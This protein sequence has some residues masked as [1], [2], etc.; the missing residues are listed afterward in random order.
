MEEKSE[1]FCLAAVGQEAWTLRRILE[2][3]KTYEIYLAAVAQDGL[4]LWRIKNT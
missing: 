4:A 2:K 3:L 1:T